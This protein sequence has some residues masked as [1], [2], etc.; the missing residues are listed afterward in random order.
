[1]IQLDIRHPEDR[2][3]GARVRFVAD[4]RI[5][6]E[7]TFLRSY[8]EVTKNTKFE[9]VQDSGEYY[10]KITEPT[11]ELILERLPQIAN[12]AVNIWYVTKET[13]VCTSSCMD[14]KSRICVC[15]C[16]GKNHKNGAFHK[17]VSH[18]ASVPIDPEFQLLIGSNEDIEQQEL[19]FPR[20]TSLE[21]QESKVSRIVADYT[22]QYRWE[23][24]EDDVDSWVRILNYLTGE[25][26][27]KFY[28]GNR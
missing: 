16:K 9:G 17:G 15:A 27:I 23:Y 19:T 26:P 5:S 20:N 2:F 12:V 11:A 13:L 4:R 7:V 22:P 21:E 18:I 8:L 28:P 14:A 3:K 10:Y 1:M 25:W 6:N 24:L